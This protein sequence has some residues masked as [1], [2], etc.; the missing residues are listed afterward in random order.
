LEKKKGGGL[1]VGK[2]NVGGLRMGKRGRDNGVKRGSV[3][4]GIKG[5]DGK[6]EG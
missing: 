2:E 4:S 5:R 3:S 6:R 1:C